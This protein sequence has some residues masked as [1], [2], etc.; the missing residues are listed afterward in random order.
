MSVTKEKIQAGDQLNF[1]DPKSN[2]GA[3]E[4]YCVQC[5]RKV[6]AN[7]WYAEVINGGDIR[8]QDGT[9]YDT[10]SDAGYMGCWPVGN[11]CAKSFAPNILFKMQKA[12]A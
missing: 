11:E 10:A 7:P 2:V 1:V 12:G 6:G 9:E 3:T 4:G 5:G 8:L